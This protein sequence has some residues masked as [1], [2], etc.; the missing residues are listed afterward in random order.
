MMDDIWDPEEANAA[1]LYVGFREVEVGYPTSI[2]VT[3]DQAEA[4]L[5]AEEGETVRLDKTRWICL[6]PGGEAL[7]GGRVYHYYHGERGGYGYVLA[8]ETE[9]RRGLASALADTDT[10]TDA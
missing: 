8:D 4:I 1:D 2:C 5:A 9:L 3:A 7:P 10:D 6:Q